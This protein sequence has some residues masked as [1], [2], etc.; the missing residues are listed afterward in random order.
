M[1]YKNIWVIIEKSDNKPVQVCLEILG[2]GRE[3]ADQK[4]EKLVAVLIGE[5]NEESAKM[6]IEYGADEVINV[7]SPLYKHY[8]TDGFTT[9]L[10]QLIDKYKPFAI[11]IGATNNGKDLG[12]RISAR[13]KLGLVAHCTDIYWN[14]EKTDLMWVRPTFDGKLYS[15]I[16][17]AT[18]PQ[19]GSLGSNVFRGNKPDASRQGVI[20][21]ETIELSLED[22]RTKV[23]E[24]IKNETESGK[25]VS[26]K[27][28][29]IVVSCGLGI[30]EEKNIQIVKDFAKLVG[31]ALGCTKPLVDKGWLPQE[32]QVGTTG[33]KVAPKIYFAFGI[34]GALP[35]IGGMKKSDLIIAVNNDPDAPIFKTAHYGIV[36][37]LFKVIPALTEELKDIF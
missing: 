22:I 9:V 24:F 7:E 23:L 16:L 5:N 15:T 33:T 27:D 21:N 19:I 28:A 14:E 26:L 12:G 10:D 37:D 32:N 2:K 36:G 25:E 29:K 1:E 17:T 18:L 20:T 31:G 4:G 8:T 6:L 11:L 35:H 34:S 30:Q 13:R 3:L